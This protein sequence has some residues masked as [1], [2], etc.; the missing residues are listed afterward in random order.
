MEIYL[1]QIIEDKTAQPNK[2]FDFF[3]AIHQSRIMLNKSI[4][5][6]NI[7]SQIAFVC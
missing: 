6:K 7:L 1:H 2:N 3:N 5:N 4:M